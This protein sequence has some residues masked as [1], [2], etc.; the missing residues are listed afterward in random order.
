MKEKNL[1][2]ILLMLIGIIIMIAASIGLGTTIS[3]QIYTKKG[4]YEVLSGKV[5]YKLQQQPD[6]TIIWVKIK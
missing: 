6:S 4:H 1:D 2:G 3:K 5:K